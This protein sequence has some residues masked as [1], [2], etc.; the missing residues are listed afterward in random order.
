MGDLKLIHFYESD[1][2]VLF[3][4]SKDIGEQRDV[5]KQMPAE[6]KQLSNRLQKHL[7]AVDAQ[8]PI[9]NPNYD[10]N[11]TPRQTKG[12]KGGIKKQK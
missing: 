1:R 3:D 10:P 8:F 12:G 5:S 11:A 2:E 4:L 9:V 6:T 7:A